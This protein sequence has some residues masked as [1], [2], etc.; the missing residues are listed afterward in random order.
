MVVTRIGKETSEPIRFNKGLPQGD[1]LCPRL[2]TVCLNPIAW[3]ISATEGYRLFKPIS[4]KV[5]DLQNID[6][7]KIF[8]ASGS[9]LNRVMNMVNTTMEDVGLAWNPK[10]CAVG[11]CEE[12][13][14]RE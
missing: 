6:D 5:T 2:F 11:S 10:K 9:K 14:A 3:K 8:A 7:L 4:F 1:A 13:S 12:R